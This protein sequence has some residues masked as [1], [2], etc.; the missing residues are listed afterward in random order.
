LP[1]PIWVSSSA[2]GVA[3]RK[4]AHLLRLSAEPE[5]AGMR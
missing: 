4:I 3:S 2:M 1:V 5:A